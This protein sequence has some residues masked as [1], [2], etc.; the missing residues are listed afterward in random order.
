MVRLFIMWKMEVM[1]MNEELYEIAKKHL[2]QLD[3][4]KIADIEVR[5]IEGEHD[6]ERGE[7]ENN[8]QIDIYYK[9]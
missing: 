4:S 1:T 9:E 2:E 6:F 5:H 8:I 7:R 3:V